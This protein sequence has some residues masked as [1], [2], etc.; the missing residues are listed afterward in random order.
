[1]KK[2]S[3]LLIIIAI[4]SGFYLE[5]LEKSRLE[6]EKR[7]CILGMKMIQ[8]ACIIYNIEV[9]K[10]P[11][12][13]K[14]LIDKKYLRRIDRCPLNEKYKFTHSGSFYEIKCPIHGNIMFDVR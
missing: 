8:N 5:N 6:T 11:E 7:A 2:I 3:Y 9:G 14:A 1:M 4:V 12:N 10:F 13:T